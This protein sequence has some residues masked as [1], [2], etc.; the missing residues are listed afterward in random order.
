MYDAVVQADYMFH[1]E[2]AAALADWARQQTMPL[3]IVDLGCGDAWLATHAFQDANVEH[4]FGVDASESAVERARAHV[5]CWPGR[6]EV[7]CGNFADVLRQVPDESANVVLASYSLHHF[8]SEAKIGLITDYRR[9]LTLGGTFFWIDAVRGEAESRDDYVSRLTQIMQRDWLALSAEQRARA[10]G[11]V[12][13]SDFPE[14]AT[15]MR[16]QVE[17]AGFRTAGTILAEDFFAGWAFTKT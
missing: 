4:Y 1:T 9:I 10:C 16:D 3:R 5:A 11:H 12:L 2:L 6:A 13:E 14:T 15:W 8:L 7:E 17:Q